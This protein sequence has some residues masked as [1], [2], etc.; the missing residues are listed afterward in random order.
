MQ[1]Y[2]RVVWLRW[3]CLVRFTVRTESKRWREGSE[4]HTGEERNT[5]TFK[6]VNKA[7]IVRD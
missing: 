4:K 2:S 5:H 1:C 6:A 7:L 3:L